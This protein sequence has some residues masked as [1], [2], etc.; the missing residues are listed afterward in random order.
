[1]P[2]N[3]IFI[4]YMKKVEL[5]NLIKEC[6]NE[7]INEF[8]IIDTDDLPTHEKNTAILISAN[9]DNEYERIEPGNRQY[10]RPDELRKIIGGSYK[11]IDGKIEDSK[12]KVVYKED[13]ALHGFPFNFNATDVFGIKNFYGDVLVCKENQIR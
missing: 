3:L 1:M 2:Y 6:I 4:C 9:S 7:I 11:V 12:V 13:G 8:N 5:K 10:F